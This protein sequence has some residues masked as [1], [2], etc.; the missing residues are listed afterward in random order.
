MGNKLYH[1]PVIRDDKGYPD[2]VATMAN[3]EKVHALIQEG[4]VALLMSK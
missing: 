1:V 4:S 3:Y 2:L